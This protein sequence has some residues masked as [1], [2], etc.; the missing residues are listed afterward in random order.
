M[1]FFTY[2]FLFNLLHHQTANPD[3]DSQLGCV[4]RLATAAKVFKA[5]VWAAGQWLEGGEAAGCGCVVSAG[6]FRLPPAG[7]GFASEVR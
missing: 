2:F 4:G 1:G 6:G 5:M 3:A 7:L